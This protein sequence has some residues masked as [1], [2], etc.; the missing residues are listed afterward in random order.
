MSSA[1]GSTHG[2]IGSSL[3]GAAL[4]GA[5]VGLGEAAIVIA[6]RHLGLDAGL[7]YFALLSYG[8]I[9][10][11]IGLGVGIALRVIGASGPTGFALSGAG[12]L[13]VLVTIIGRFRVFRDRRR[14]GRGP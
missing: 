1:D 9:G 13:A 6:E 4:A 5:L 12:L 2:V 3:A 8:G 11:L 10:A 14:L 7:L